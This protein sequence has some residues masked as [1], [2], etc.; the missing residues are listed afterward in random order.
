MDCFYIITNRLKDKDYAITEE[1]RRYIE[2]NG[3]KA[4]LSEKDEEGH[5]VPG[6]V[7]GE[8]QCALVLGGDGTLIRAVRDL[9]DRNLP[10]LGINLGTLGYLTDVELKDCPKALDRLFTGTP[11]IEERMMLEGTFRGEKRD[12]ALNDIVLTREGKMRI[13]QFNIYVN[14]TLLNTYLADGVIISTPTGSTGYNLSA[15]GPVVEPTA[16]IIVITPICSHALNTSSVVLSAEDII[17]IEICEGRYGRQEEVSL[18]FD[19]VEP[20][21]LV[22]GERVR[23]CRA[24]ETVRL[25]KLHKES[26]LT[27][28]RK[29]MKGN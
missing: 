3:R 22:T 5:I 4:I 21:K 13:V 16:K 8:V 29:K 10:L 23:I 20:T 15:G 26:F 17:E 14:G 12:L 19:G 18:C 25:I 2:K 6:T 28:M 27:T 7:P 11:E 24:K 1:I 9:G